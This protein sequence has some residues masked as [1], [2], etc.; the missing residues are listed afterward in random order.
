[1]ADIPTTARGIMK[2]ASPD[3]IAIENDRMIFATD[4]GFVLVTN[5]G[6]GLIVNRAP[7]GFT[8]PN[9]HRRID[10]DPVY[11]PGVHYD[12]VHYN[13]EG[14]PYKQ[15]IVIGVWDGI[16]SYRTTTTYIHDEES[17]TCEIP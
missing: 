3:D 6:E 2:P 16:N 8:N 1:M 17:T 10:D 9:L 11:K 15:S 5:S 14:E 12:M 4:D 13:E 7:S